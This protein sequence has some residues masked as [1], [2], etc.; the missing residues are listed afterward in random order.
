MGYKCYGG[1]YKRRTF[2]L[3]FRLVGG[4]EGFKPE[5]SDLAILHKKKKRKRSNPWG[6]RPEQR[7]KQLW[8][9]E[10]GGGGVSEDG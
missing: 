9:V 7:P 5:T 6:E 3:E 8:E 4:R 2:N 10:M 1:E